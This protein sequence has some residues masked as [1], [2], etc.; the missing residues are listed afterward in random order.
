MEDERNTMLSQPGLLSS[1]E[2]ET[3]NVPTEQDPAKPRLAGPAVTSPK[4][5][6]WQ[7]VKAPRHVATG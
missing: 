4:A 1:K 2:P 6:S 3:W 5:A 7:Q